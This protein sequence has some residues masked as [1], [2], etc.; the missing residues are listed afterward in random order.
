MLVGW[1]RI[2]SMNISTEISACT[3]Y[4]ALIKLIEDQDSLFVIEGSRDYCYSGEKIVKGLKLLESGKV[5]YNVLTRGQG[6]RRKAMEL[7]GVDEEIIDYF[8]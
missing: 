3:T 7:L 2:L 4:A 5:P 1:H 8:N 6:L